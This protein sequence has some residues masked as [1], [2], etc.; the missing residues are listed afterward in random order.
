MAL[1][2]ISIA[3]LWLEQD[4]CGHL[5][6]VVSISE[7]KMS[8]QDPVPDPSLAKIPSGDVNVGYREK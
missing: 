3:V 1:L 4:V 6:S 2:F 7:S 5:C 8:L